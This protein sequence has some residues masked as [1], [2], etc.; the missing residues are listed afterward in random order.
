MRILSILFFAFFAVLLPSLPAQRPIRFAPPPEMVPNEFL[1]EQRI[2]A[3]DLDRDG[4]LDL[5]V[6]T[7]ISAS[8]HR[9]WWNLGNASFREERDVLRVVS[10][11]LPLDVALADLDHD[12]D[13]DLI[14][15][16][17]PLLVWEN[18]Y[19]DPFLPM[20]T[21][22]PFDW[23]SIQWT[24]AADF[25]SNGHTDVF[26]AVYGQDRL[27]LADGANPWTFF[28]RSSLLPPDA[29][30]TE[31]AIAGDW[32]RDGWLDIAAAGDGSLRILLQ[33]PSTA[34]FVLAQDEAL[35]QVRSLAAGDVDGDGFPDLFAGREGQ[36]ILLRNDGRGGFRRTLAALPDHHGTT[37]GAVFVDHERDGD[38]DLVLAHRAALP[39]ECW[40]RLLANDG[41]G[42]F[43]EAARLG[44]EP[45]ANWGVIAADLDEDR[46][47]DLLFLSTRESRATLLLAEGS[48]GYQEAPLALPG[49]SGT[50]WDV[51][52][53][54]FDGVAGVDAALLLFPRFPYEPVRPSLLVYLGDVLGRFRWQEAAVPADLPRVDEMV[55]AD[56]DGDGSRDLFLR[57]EPTWPAAAYHTLLLNDGHARFAEKAGAVPAAYGDSTWF[58]AGDLDGDGDVDLFLARPRGRTTFGLL[59]NR[60]DGS[61]DDAS[62][63][64]PASPFL[65]FVHPELIDLDGDRDLDVVIGPDG[66]GSDGDPIRIYLNDG[67]AGFT[68]SPAPL[69]AGISQ[70]DG[71]W[72]PGDFDRDGDLDL[73]LCSYF[74]V[75]RYLLFPNDGSGRFL[76]MVVGAFP[77]LPRKVVLDLDA[78]DIENDGDLDLASCG[79]LGTHEIFL[80]D[81]TGRFQLNGEPIPGHPEMLED[82]AIGFADTD[83]D[84]DADMFV[85]GFSTLR[86]LLNLD[87]QVRWRALPRVGRPLEIEVHGTAGGFYWLFASA[88]TLDRPTPYGRL[89]VDPRALAGLRSGRLDAGGAAVETTLV[90]AN[91]ALVGARFYLQ[92]L[93]DSP[94]R[95]S[96]LE[97]AELEGL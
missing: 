65:H 76:P 17:A 22:L 56:F 9:I 73:V 58:R 75:Q 43:R 15:A 19:P 52:F 47:E 85:G 3:G 69:P 77:L 27:Y 79:K 25:D 97:V 46:D 20:A 84:G 81:G 49:F 33:D 71:S 21:G 13:P 66:L 2:E 70:A 88:G 29:R 41:H 4:D 38:L 23:P 59:L 30:S 24:L 45:L 10:G 67:L 68:E 93:L 90:P 53:S 26:L 95:L 28:D 5:F 92:A 32:N 94:L 8:D 87:R 16:G 74:P 39:E 34:R 91:P 6:T 72:V 51:D 1:H 55:G 31:C 54:D 12:G 44:A 82:Y 11:P 86:Y 36:D 64:T 50:F 14:A 60:G 63:T 61:F 62:A 96:N 78:V 57:V 42:R 35:G 89:R 83:E 37:T 18:R 40:N 7:L 48:G 80:N